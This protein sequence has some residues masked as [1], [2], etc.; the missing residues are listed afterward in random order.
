MVASNPF[1]LAITVLF[2]QVRALGFDEVSYGYGKARMDLECNVA[3]QAFLGSFLDLANFDLAQAF[4]VVQEFGMG[5]V[6]ELWS[7][8]S[9]VR[10]IRESGEVDS[11]RRYECQR[12]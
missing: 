5:G 10:C 11:H 3:Y 6:D 4:D 8:V 1:T 12:R 7:T 2:S 9:I